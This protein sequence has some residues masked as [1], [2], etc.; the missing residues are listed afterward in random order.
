MLCRK[1]GNLFVHNGRVRGGVNAL[2]VF[3]DQHLWR[4][5]LNLVTSFNFTGHLAMS[6]QVEVVWF[7]F[8]IPLPLPFQA[9]KGHGADIAAR[10]VF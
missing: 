7:N 9:A 2:T 3:N 1:T 10:A 4:F 8:F 5:V 6:N